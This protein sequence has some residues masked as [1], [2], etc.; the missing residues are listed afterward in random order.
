MIEPRDIHWLAGLVEGEGCFRVDQKRKRI[1]FAMQMTD[2]DIMQRAASILDDRVYGPYKNGTHKPMYRIH[3]P[4]SKTIQW[5][6]T[7]YTLLGARRQQAI[8]T[9]IA[10]WKSTKSQTNRNRK[11][12]K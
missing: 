9:L 3:L 4:P 7:L 8:R 1:T 2:L 12:F 6:M 10:V 11:G 5:A